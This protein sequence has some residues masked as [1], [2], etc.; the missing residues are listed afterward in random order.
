MKKESVEIGE[1][2]WRRL[3]LMLLVLVALVCTAAAQAPPKTQ[4]NPIGPPPQAKSVPSP[5]HRI[6]PAE[7]KELLNSVDEVLKFDSDSS[8][9]PI[10]QKIKRQLTDRGQVQ[11]YIEDNIRDDPDAQRLKKAQTV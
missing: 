8:G 3:L 11:K 7:A 10:K 5:E 2:P 1:L 4:P 9:L 6:T